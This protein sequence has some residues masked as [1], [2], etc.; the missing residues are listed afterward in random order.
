MHED[1]PDL[2]IARPDERNMLVWHYLLQ[3]PPD[4]D[5]VGGWYWGR[6]K[7]PKNYPMGPP[8]IY[9]ITPNGRFE[10]NKRLC[11]SISD[12][13]PESWEPS[14]TVGTVLTGLLSFM[15]ESQVT[16]GS[17]ETSTDKKRNFA[18]DSIDWNLAQDDFMNIFADFDEIRENAQGGGGASSSTAK[19]KAEDEADEE[20]EEIKRPDVLNEMD[21]AT[22]PLSV[23][24]DAE[25]EN[26]EEPPAPPPKPKES[27]KKEERLSTRSKE[28]PFEIIPNKTKVIIKGLKSKPYFNGMEGS[29]FGTIKNRHKIRVNGT[30]LAL[31]NT[32]FDVVGA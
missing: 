5:Y 28:V 14:W 13:H 8:S 9:M 26:E 6:L 29:V 31:A 3:G 25:S 19:P 23:F 7:F 30:A 32:N 24:H 20:S 17:I 11:L 18:F 12:Y 22:K 27:I 21:D 15:C 10:V 16:T 1:P 4:T 2:I